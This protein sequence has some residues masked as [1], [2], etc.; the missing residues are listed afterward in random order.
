MPSLR[1]GLVPL[2][3]LAV[4]TVSLPAQGDHAHHV[5][6]RIGRVAF[7]TTCRASVQ[8]RFESAVALLHSFWYEEAAAA[9][10]DAARGD[11]TCSLAYWGAAMSRLH[12]LW[13][14]PTPA[15]EAAG[16]AAAD[17]AMRTSRPGTRE[18]HYAE[19]IFGFF[20]NPGHRDFR[21]RIFAWESAMAAV[22]R[23]HPGDDEARIFHGLSQIA[24]G[25]L[26]P[27]DTTYHRQREAAAELTP[28]IPRYPDHPGLAHYVIH[29]FDSPALARY[30]LEAANHYAAIAPAVPHALH[31]PSHIFIR[32]GM[33]PE[34]I[35]SN[36]HSAEAARQAEVAAGWT[37]VWT[38][39][40]HALDYEAY[41]HLQLGQDSAARALVEQ[42]AA[43]SGMRPEQD[44]VGYYALAAIPA[45]YALERDDWDA[46]TQLR[47]RPAPAWRGTEAITRFAR[48]I[49]AARRGDSTLAVAEAG[50]LGR[51]EEALRQAAGP[52]L[53]WAGQARNQRLAAEAWIDLSRGDTAA[54]LREA[55]AAADT[56]DV[57]EKHP[58]TPGPVLPAR[59]LYAD[60]LLQVGRPRE[61]AAEYRAT[62]E[63]QPNRLRARRGLEQAH[64]YSVNE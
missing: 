6:A 59:E 34:A 50:E 58:V 46:A 24:A 43:V 41:A 49:G 35:A 9:F 32:L 64:A 55:R 23:Q 19:A 29:A 51:I 20:S 18:R 21:T 7:P 12:P 38:Q 48:A 13:T 52:Q 40:L 16:L 45:R 10:E 17:L 56:E 4:P 61:A 31:M 60:M 3:L 27:T 26:D 14:P 39:R 15:E 44:L 53:Y 30:A 1:R 2:L 11:S 25:Q 5:E 8:S 33:W 37:T 57:T 42:A 36:Q 54:A 62:L 22:V 28:L 63:R 47:V